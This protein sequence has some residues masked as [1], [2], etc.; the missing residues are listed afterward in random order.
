M[1]RSICAILILTCLAASGCTTKKSSDSESSAAPLS[2]TTAPLGELLFEGEPTT[3]VAVNTTAGLPL[4]LTTTTGVPTPPPLGLQEIAEWEPHEL[5]TSSSV[6]FVAAV[7]R[8]TCNTGRT[9][10]VFP[11][12]VTYSEFEVVVTFMVVSTH[13]FDC[14]GN[15][16]VLYRVELSEPIGDRRLFD[17]SCLPAARQGLGEFGAIE[18]CSKEAQNG[19]AVPYYPPGATMG[20]GNI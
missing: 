17:G 19:F 8:I 12:T 5:V 16:P 9:A 3:T 13:T 20:Y 1:R 6:S 18:T 7:N 4:S 14:P 15:R 11:P 10:K 2:G